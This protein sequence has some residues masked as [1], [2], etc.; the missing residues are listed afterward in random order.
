MARTPR[1]PEPGLARPLA[2]MMVEPSCGASLFIFSRLFAS[3]RFL[4]LCSEHWNDFEQCG[5]IP[6]NLFKSRLR[7]G[8]LARSSRSFSANDAIDRPAS[9]ETVVTPLPSPPNCTVVHVGVLYYEKHTVDRSHASARPHLLS[10]R[11]RGSARLEHASH[12]R[13]IRQALTGQM[14]MP[15]PVGHQLSLSR[16]PWHLFP[17]PHSAPRGMGLPQQPHCRP[18]PTT[19]RYCD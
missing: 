13:I 2:G 11:A 9:V 17:Y 15:T 16:L 3:A 19:T 7:T 5:D 6:G 18:R 8:S 10:H 14:R 12:T 1:Q 4:A